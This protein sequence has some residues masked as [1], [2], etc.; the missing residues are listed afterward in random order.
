MSFVGLIMR[1]ID[2]ADGFQILFYRSISL[3]AVIMIVACLKRG[4]S[5]LGFLK[6]L[7][8]YDLAM[9]MAL[10]L[11]FATYIFAMLMTSVASTLFILT[12]SPFLAALIAWMWIGEKPKPITWLAMCAASLGVGLMIGDGLTTGRTGGNL[13]AIL[14]ALMFALMLVIARRSRKSD[15]L[16]GTFMGGVFAC[17]LAVVCA[18]TLG[19]GLT[20]EPRDIALA[21]FM[22]AFTIGIGITFVTWCG[23]NISPEAIEHTVMKIE[24]VAEAVVVGIPNKV[25]EE[26]IA[27]FFAPNRMCR[28]PG[29]I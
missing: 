18:F 16:G 6:W 1:L 20:V 24:G 14:S 12:A 9:G 17:V 28:S 27:C 21:L 13:I 11:A 19:D 15:V 4:S 3:S 23:E 29:R 8:R 10:S 26:M 22:G 7:D 25:L 5:P 2:S